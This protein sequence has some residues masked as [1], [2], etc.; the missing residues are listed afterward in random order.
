MV[1][2][3]GI[4]ILKYLIVYQLIIGVWFK[5]VVEHSIVAFAWEWQLV[6]I[7]RQ[8]IEIKMWDHNLSRILKFISQQI[9]IGILKN[10]NSNCLP[11]L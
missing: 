8:D 7:V 11:Q 4:M 10:C 2:Q 6:E 9:F 1:R 3:Q 5:I